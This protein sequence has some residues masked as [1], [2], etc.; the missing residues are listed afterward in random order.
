M[1]GVQTCALPIL[2]ATNALG[3]DLP[4]TAGVTNGGVVPQ[5]TTTNGSSVVTVT[6]PDHQY[7]DGDTYPAL[8][9]TS[10]GG[11]TIY[12]NYIV[13]NAT[14]NSYQI[15]ASSAATETRY[16]VSSQY[17]PSDSNSNVL[18]TSAGFSGDVSK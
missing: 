10:V 14:T 13:A 5:Y 18:T 17:C 2:T 9:S 6:F 15:V 8:I 16:A 1:T 12:G 3:A 4:A 11:V 7:Q